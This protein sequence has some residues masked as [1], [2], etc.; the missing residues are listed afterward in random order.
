MFLLIESRVFVE[1]VVIKNQT[2]DCFLLTHSFILYIFVHVYPHSRE[3]HD[4]FNG[5]LSTLC[6]SFLYVHKISSLEKKN[7]YRYLKIPRSVITS[8]G[9]SEEQRTQDKTHARYTHWQERK[10]K[11]I[12]TK[13]LNKREL[14]S[15]ML[16]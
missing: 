12:R 14:L 13:K 3:R 9:G 7:Y 2:S 5:V 10:N 8:D 11:K 16:R 1:G 4:F 6:S 15:L